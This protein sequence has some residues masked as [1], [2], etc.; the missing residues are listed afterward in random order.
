MSPAFFLLTKWWGFHTSRAESFHDM[1]QPVKTRFRRPA[2]GN[3]TVF[4]CRNMEYG[5]M[6]KC[7]LLPGRC[8]ND[9]RG[10]S[11]HAPQDAHL[12]IRETYLYVVEV[13]CV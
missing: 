9:D 7:S 1:G 4:S 12:A 5:M 10:A 6:E 2:F 3:A 11:A 13:L 8:I